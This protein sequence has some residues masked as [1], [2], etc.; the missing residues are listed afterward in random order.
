MVYA[1]Q[2][3]SVPIPYQDKFVRVVAGRASGIKMTNDAGRDTDDP[4][5]LVSS[6]TVSCGCLYW[7]HSFWTKREMWL[8]FSCC[9]RPSIVLAP[10]C[11]SARWAWL[12][13]N[14]HATGCHVGL[15]DS[16]ALGH[17]CDLFL[18]PTFCYQLTRFV[19]NKGL[20]NGWTGNWPVKS[21]AR[22]VAR[23]SS[24]KGPSITW[25]IPWNQLNKKTS[26]SIN[27]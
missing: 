24:L 2:H 1:I 4:S 21:P 12:S 6:R 25:N 11:H 18:P 5:D 17:T 7:P 23:G 27:V 26:T 16:M 19:L 14:F 8:D 22:S 13:C 3:N 15:I 10:V 9:Q 20:L